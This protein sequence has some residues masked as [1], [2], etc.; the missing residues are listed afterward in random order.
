MIVSP[1]MTTQSAV[2]IGGLNEDR[3]GDLISTRLDYGPIDYV[4]NYA[5]YYKQKIHPI[6]AEIHP[7][8]Y[9]I[10]NTPSNKW[11]TQI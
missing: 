11:G 5:H 2:G 4:E 10:R 9:K 1:I 7:I 8:V 3:G 6:V